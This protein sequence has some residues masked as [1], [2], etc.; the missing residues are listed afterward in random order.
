MNEPIKIEWLADLEGGLIPQGRGQLGTNKERCCL[1]V[2][3]DI[4]VKHGVIKSK[5]IEGNWIYNDDEELVLP[6]EVIKWAG[7]N[8]CIAELDTRIVFN[9]V[10]CIT[11]ADL[12][13]EGMDF[14]SIAKVIR[15]HF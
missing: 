2:L 9:K 6:P 15:E 10:K 3:C 4:A 7:L 12:N 14:P 5:N 11:L 13:D 1:G 8:S